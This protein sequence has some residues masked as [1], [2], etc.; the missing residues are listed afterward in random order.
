VT[1]EEL[2]LL[3]GCFR[4]AKDDPKPFSSNSC[5]QLGRFDGKTFTPVGDIK[6]AHEGPNFYG[7]LI[8]NNAPQGRHIMMGWT[9]GTSLPPGEKFNQSASVP[10]ELTLKK[11][12]N[13]DTLCFEPVK[14]LE[15]LRGT[16]LLN[17]RNVSVADA[18]AKLAALTK[19]AQLDIAVRFKPAAGS[20]KFRARNVELAYDPATRTVTRGRQATVIHPDAAVDV[21]F[22]MDRGLIETFW[23]GGEASYCIGSAYTAEGPAFSITGEANIEEL[24]V[25]PMSDIWAQQ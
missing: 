5:Y 4:T 17:L 12:N 21:R 8:F 13:E 22:L 25:H 11:R 14:E 7:A 10:L 16:P 9:R 18:Q 2:W 20:L 24:T 15:A 6:N 19:D 23:N 3:Y 1:G